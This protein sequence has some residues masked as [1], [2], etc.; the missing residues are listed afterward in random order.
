VKIGFITYGCKVNRYET[1]RIKQA[2]LGGGNTESTEPDVYVIN[3]CTVTGTIDREIAR[4]IRQI[5]HN[6][7]KVLLT[8][9]LAERGDRAG[10]EGLAD[11]IVPNSGKCS[12]EAYPPEITAGAPAASPGEVLK[13]FSNINKAFIKIEDGCNRFCSYCEIPFV[14]GSAVRSRDSKEIL[15]E[16]SALS[17]AGYEEIVLTG[18]NLGLFGAEKNEPAALLGLLEKIKKLGLPL[19]VRLSSIGPRDISAGIIAFAAENPGFLCPHFH[20]SAQSGSDDVLKMMGRPY[21]AEYYTDKARAV[22]SAVPRAAVTTDI[23]T[24]FP[25]ETEKMH[26]ETV[27]FIKKT[28]LSRIHVFTYSDRPDTTA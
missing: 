14:R 27:E 19:R 12:V 9:C 3:T 7:K 18:I 23:I 2:L 24:G 17:R 11:W 1:E 13:S 16:I 10:F 22:V 25:G 21:T 15:E 20:M 26:M 28:S 4:K 8:G 5:K 6:N